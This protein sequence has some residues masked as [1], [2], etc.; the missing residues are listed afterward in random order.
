VD[1]ATRR[2]RVAGCGEAIEEETG[3]VAMVVSSVSLRE[4]D[5]WTVRL[6]PGLGTVEDPGALGTENF[7]KDTGLNAVGFFMDP[8]RA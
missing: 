2:G 4:E 5:G 1:F 3:V 6:S 8:V 7:A